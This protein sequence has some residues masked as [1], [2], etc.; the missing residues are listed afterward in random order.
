[1]SSASMAYAA[2]GSG[3]LSLTFAAPL[4]SGGG[5]LTTRSVARIELTEIAW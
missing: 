2:G 4:F 1:M 3:E 5:T